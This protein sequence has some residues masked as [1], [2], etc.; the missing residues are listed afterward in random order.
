M[1]TLPQIVPFLKL[2]SDGNPERR[3]EYYNQSVAHAE[4]IAK[5]FGRKYPDYLNVNRPK[6]RKEYRDYRAKIY[7][8]PFRSLHGK[9]LKALKYIRQADDFDIVF[10]TQKEK[11][12]TLKEYV[13]SPMF[14]KKG[15]MQDWFFE[16]V[17]KGY[18]NDPNAVMCVIPMQQ[19][20]SDQ[21]YARPVAMLIP[22]E[23]VYM[24]REGTFAVL[25]APEKVPI[26]GV[27]GITAGKVLIFVDAESY[28][29]AR[30]VQVQ[31]AG[32]KEYASWQI[33][34]LLIDEVTGE[35]SFSPPLHNCPLMPAVKVGQDCTQENDEGE[36]CYESILSG[37]FE[38][39]KEGQAVESDIQVERNFHVS[40]QE[41]RYS[42]KSTVCKARGC[43]GGTITAR[44]PISGNVTGK[45]DCPTCKGS[46][47]GA[48]SGS[49][50]DLIEV[51][52]A[53]ATGFDNEGRPMNIPTPP[54]GFIP[55]PVESIQELRKEFDRYSREAYAVVNMQ[56]MRETPI[57]Q[58]GTAKRY[59]REEMYREL[60]TVGGHIC[61]ML[62]NGLK[63]VGYQRYGKVVT[64]QLPTVIEPIRFNL[65]NAELTREELKEAKDKKFDPNIQ[66]P[67]TKRLIEYRAGK[68][69]DYYRKFEL[70]EKLDPYPGMQPEEKLFLLSTMYV[71]LRGDPEAL[72]VSVEAVWLSIN[73]DALISELQRTNPDF[74]TLDLSEQFTMMV[75]A[76]KKR[77]GT[78]TEQLIDPVTGEP[79][80]G[81]A[82]LQPVVNFKNN[83]KI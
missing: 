3:H 9:V 59:D 57:D 45:I 39:V 51:S 30:Q 82:V 31:Q 5:V 81:P 12:D 76:N 7:K 63:W 4:E 27:E 15:S 38:A 6:E 68:E 26:Q 49:G 80:K 54:G 69:S 34:G 79:F 20:A 71:L 41:W 66:N 61:R 22:S 40:A 17:G 18:V 64:D 8:N 83:G 67:L 14:S 62:E 43:E 77:V 74:L 25:G 36:T 75:E 42:P 65:E 35:A 11:T 24:H 72:K 23:R 47:R 73:F 60:N 1:L 56:F 33:D 46:G 58:S 78:P 2:D 70:K 52:P 10:P 53:T 19:P 55:R 16:K 13:E 28:C 44:D 48:N 32:E 50:L 37:A 29:V 21:D